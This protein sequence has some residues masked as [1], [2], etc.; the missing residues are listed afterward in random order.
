MIQDCNKFLPRV[1]GALRT[2]GFAYAGLP[3]KPINRFLEGETPSSRSWI[4][5]FIPLM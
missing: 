4:S 5:G 1:S 2:G 3:I